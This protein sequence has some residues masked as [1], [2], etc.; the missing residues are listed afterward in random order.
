LFTIESP[1]LPLT[2]LGGPDPYLGVPMRQVHQGRGIMQEHFD[3]VAAH[4][5]ATLTGAGLDQV[6]VDEIIGLVAPLAPEIVS[7][8]A[9]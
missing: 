5:I 9:A 4:L 6:T 7:T 8:P 2:T 3:L 1:L